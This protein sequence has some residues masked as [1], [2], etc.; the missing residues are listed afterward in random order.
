MDR[1]RRRRIQFAGQQLAFRFTTPW[2]LEGKEVAPLREVTPMKVKVE[3]NQTDVDGDYG[4]VDGIC[5]VCTR[6]G[7]DVNVA[8][9]GEASARR[10]AAMLHE[11][12]PM[13]ENNFYD[14]DHWE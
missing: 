11:E 7:H 4:S 10:G 5:L 6:C 3:I 14:V 13:N 12:C 2:E 9:I 1:L 8:G